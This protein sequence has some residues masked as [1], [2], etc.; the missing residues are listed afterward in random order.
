MYNI[1]LGIFPDKLKTAKIIHIYKAADSE[2]FTN[3]R[4]IFQFSQIF[5]GYA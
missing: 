4:P 3:Y 2:F 5:S 1:P